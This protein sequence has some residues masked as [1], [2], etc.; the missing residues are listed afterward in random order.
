MELEDIG[1]PKVPYIHFT[2]KFVMIWTK[3]SHIKDF[4]GF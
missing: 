3:N 2:S 1:D 4:K